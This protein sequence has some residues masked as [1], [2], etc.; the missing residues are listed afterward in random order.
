MRSGAQFYAWL[1]RKTHRTIIQNYIDRTKDNPCMDC[2]VKYPPYC[3]DFDHRD[4]Q[5]KVDNVSVLKKG[6]LNKVKAEIAK[7]DLVCATCHRKRT[8]RNNRTTTI[9]S[10]TTYAIN[11]HIK[12][13]IKRST[14]K[15]PV[16]K[17]FKPLEKLKKQKYGRE[18][19]E[20]KQSYYIRNKKRR[21]EYQRRYRSNKV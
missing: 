8:W 17:K 16:F 15:M 21:L 18:R 5:D 14:A 19:R 4:P 6:S 11:L 13:E 20:Y 10:Y 9:E 1:S 12:E 2:G 7:C 3:M